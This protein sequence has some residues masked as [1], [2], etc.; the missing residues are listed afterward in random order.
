MIAPTA[1]GTNLNRATSLRAD[2]TSIHS[3]VR[4]HGVY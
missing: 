2:F 4:F 1:S 3:L